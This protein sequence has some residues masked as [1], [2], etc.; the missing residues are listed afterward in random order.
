MTRLSIAEL[1]SHLPVDALIQ[2]GKPKIEWLRI[3]NV[4]FNDPFFHETVDRIRRQQPQLQSVYT[5]LDALLQVAKLVKS[6]RPSGFIFHTSRCGSTLVA[7]ACRALN[8][9][10]VIA[11]APIIDKLISRLFTEGIPGS[12]KELIYLTLIKAAIDL[13]GPREGLSGSFY[14]V[15]FAS[16][17]ILQISL[18]RRIWPTVPIVVLYRH[19]LEIMVS[20]LRNIP[21][22]MDKDNNLQTAAAIVGVPIKQFQEMSN[23]EFCARALG[24]YYEAVSSVSEDLLIMT[25]NYDQL[26][27]DALRAVLQYFSAR[28]SAAEL[29]ALEVI[30]QQHSKDTTR[31][32]QPDGLDKRQS[33]SNNEVQ[34]TDRWAMPAYARL[35]EL[36]GRERDGFNKN[37]S[38]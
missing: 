10:R 37:N 28:P 38:C 12:T 22:W 3:A 8:N 11:E 25:L 33:A 7:N 5:D 36:S 21:Q 34:M 6:A 24:R 17:S 15:K 20:N 9:S 27:V 18:I 31:F 4:A 26:S 29:N 13:L 30:S 35:L 32:F 14:I 1:S 16:V 23:G 2:N 19:P